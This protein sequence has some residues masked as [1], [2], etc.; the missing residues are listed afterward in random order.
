MMKHVRHWKMFSEPTYTEKENSSD[1]WYACIFVY[2]ALRNTS[3]PKDILQ[4]LETLLEITH[5]K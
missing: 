5:A 3:A 1:Y 4:I 2:K